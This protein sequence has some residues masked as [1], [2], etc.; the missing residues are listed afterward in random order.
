MLLDYRALLG[1]TY[2]VLCGLIT[3]IR[4]NITLTPTDMPSTINT[5]NT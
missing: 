5:H 3:L 4:G 2:V 1:L